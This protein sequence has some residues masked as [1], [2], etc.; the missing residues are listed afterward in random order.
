MPVGLI[1]TSY[2]WQATGS[3]I[4]ALRS[5]VHAL[6]GWPTPLGVAFNPSAG[7]L[8]N[9]AGDLAQ[10]RDQGQIDMLAGQVV[11]FARM[12]IAARA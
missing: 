8:F 3:T 5:I 12:R 4:A 1:A 7:P 9:D 2:G 6:R 11:D 10:P